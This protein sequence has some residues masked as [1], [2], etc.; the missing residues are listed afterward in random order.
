MSVV[1][2]FFSS[3]DNSSGVFPVAFIVL[4]N[5]ADQKEI[6][7]KVLKQCRKDLQSYAIPEIIRII[8]KIPLTPVGKVDYRELERIA[9]DQLL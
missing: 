9:E 2:L 5:N 7:E 1:L 8:D 4:K 3:K 6:T